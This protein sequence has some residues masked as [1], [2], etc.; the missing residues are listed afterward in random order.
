M[1]FP[2]KK[3]D[4][5]DKQS[6]KNILL[7]AHQ[8]KKT[9]VTILLGA[10]VSAS[11]GLPDW[12]I[13]LKRICSIFFS[14]WELSINDNK[15]NV[16][17]TNP[18]KDLSIL[19]TKS[20]FQTKNSKK[21]GSEFATS[22]PLL[23]A[24]KIKNCISKKDWNYLLNKVLYP[25]DNIS[26]KSKL[27]KEITE[28]IE[29]LIDQNIETNIINYNYDSVLENYLSDNKI[30]YNVIFKRHDIKNNR[31]KSGVNIYHPHGYIKF[32]GGPKSKIILTE[33]EYHNELT[34]PYTWSNIIQITKFSS[35]T[36]VFIGCSMV[37][38]NIRKLL[39]ACSGIFSG[40]HFSFL[41]SDSSIGKKGVLYESLFN[42]DLTKLNIM[43][44][45][46]PLMDEPKLKY[47]RLPKLIN[48]LKEI[49]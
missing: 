30:D 15:N 37:D 3:I 13:L 19:T 43:P 28:L 12:T 11:V 24:Q 31:V 40:R 41:S 7:L 6:A 47:S 18:P 33:E 21:Y 46:Y 38:P 49:I 20:F 16:S 10:G 5:L 32:K 48:Y 23:A 4:Y 8:T 45:R 26:L 17:E 14:H 22:D 25:N 2:P 27:L 35:S 29:L 1:T 9:S 44:I 36:C 42:R 34:E 39:R